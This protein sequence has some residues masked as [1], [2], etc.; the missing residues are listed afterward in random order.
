MRRTRDRAAD[1][2]NGDPLRHRGCDAAAGSKGIGSVQRRCDARASRVA[3]VTLHPSSFRSRRQRR[4][5]APLPLSSIRAPKIGCG[6]AGSSS[7][8]LR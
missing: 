5:A 1:S 7:L 2:G 8:T 6:K 3:S 4:R